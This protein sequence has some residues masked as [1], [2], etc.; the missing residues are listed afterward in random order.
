MTGMMSPVPS[1]TFHGQTH[2]STSHGRC[3][4][5]I[6]AEALGAASGSRVSV[7]ALGAIST[8]C[9]WGELGYEALT[10]GLHGTRGEFLRT[11]R[12]LHTEPGSDPC[13]FPHPSTAGTK[14]QALRGTQHRAQSTH[15]TKH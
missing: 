4:D 14:H 2:A 7:T 15:R 6:G 5:D 10:P 13:A 3:Y 1:V 12:I 9:V 8:P 11:S